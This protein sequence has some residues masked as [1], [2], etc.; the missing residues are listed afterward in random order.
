LEE[1]PQKEVIA[2]LSEF[3]YETF[4]EA[5]KKSIGPMDHI[6]DEAVVDS[7]GLLSIVE[8][9]ETKFDII[10]SDEDLDAENFDS[11]DRM[12]DLIIR[13]RG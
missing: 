12:S 13:Y 5:R 2:I 7:L 9:I 10:L 6:I 8:F 1:I 11:I 3:V 4:P